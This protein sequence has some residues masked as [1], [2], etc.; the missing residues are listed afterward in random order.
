MRRRHAKGIKSR[1]RVRMTV[2]VHLCADLKSEK[3]LYVA[4]SP[5]LVSFVNTI[6]RDHSIGSKLYVRRRRYRKHRARVSH[7]PA[8][9]IKVLMK[10]PRIDGQSCIQPS[11]SAG[12]DS[13]SV[14]T[15]WLH[16]SR[17]V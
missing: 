3:Y 12:R 4:T 14:R 7:K 6:F 10:D 11:F 2:I 1:G 16:R 5:P 17:G 15:P 13:R 8:R 9:H